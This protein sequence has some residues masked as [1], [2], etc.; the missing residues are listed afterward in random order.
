M[1]TLVPVRAGAHHSPLLYSLDSCHESAERASVGPREGRRSSDRFG[2]QSTN[3]NGEGNLSNTHLQVPR[4]ACCFRLVQSASRLQF[5][6]ASRASGP[7]VRARPPAAVE[8]ARS[9]CGIS[10]LVQVHRCLRSRVFRCLRAARG[11]CSSDCTHLHGLHLRASADIFLAQEVLCETGPLESAVGKTAL[12]ILTLH[13]LPSL[14]CCASS[15]IIG[16]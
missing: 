8:A 2:L 4:A 7:Q 14:W 1:Q 5:C 3:F 16:E 15:R 12:T 11:G 13:P 9:G 6:C 10:A